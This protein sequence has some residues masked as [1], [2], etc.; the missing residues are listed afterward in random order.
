MIGF[1]PKE[2]LMTILVQKV[3]GDWINGYLVI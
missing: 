1:S 2:L 3:N